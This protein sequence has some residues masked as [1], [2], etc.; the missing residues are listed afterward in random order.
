MIIANP[1]SVTADGV[2]KTGPGILWA[3]VLYAAS[4]DATL[5]LYDNTAASGTVLVKLATKAGTSVAF[6]PAVGVTFAIGVYADISGTDAQAT[7]I[8]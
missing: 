5:V 6:T 3:V 8:L 4:A 2:A 1:V 7:I